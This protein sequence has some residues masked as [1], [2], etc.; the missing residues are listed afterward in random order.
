MQLDWFIDASPTIAFGHRRILQCLVFTQIEHE[1]QLFLYP[2]SSFTVL[3]V[4]ATE[5]LKDKR[6]KLSDEYAH[7]EVG[8]ALKKPTII[9]GSLLAAIEGACGCSSSITK[10][11][12]RSG[13]WREVLS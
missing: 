10:S 3:K 13:V 8:R 5:N 2:L 1:L 12:G 9:K 4:R 7:L 6:A 11:R